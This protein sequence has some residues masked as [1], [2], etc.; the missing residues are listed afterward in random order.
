MYMLEKAIKQVWLP[1]DLWAGRGSL[2][3]FTPPLSL[4]CV[5]KGKDWGSSDLGY[6]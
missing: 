2:R 3:L 4:E 5:Q 6:T 1:V